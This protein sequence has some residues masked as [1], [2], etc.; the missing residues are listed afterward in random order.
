MLH[1]CFWAVKVHKT[2]IINYMLYRILF[3]DYMLYFNL[4]K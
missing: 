1:N 2:T 4:A 3:I